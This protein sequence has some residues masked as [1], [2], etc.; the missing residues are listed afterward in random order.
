MDPISVTLAS[1]AICLGLMSFI[2]ICVEAHGMAARFGS[3][4]QH[5][6]EREDERRRRRR[7]N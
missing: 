7:R 4:S 2:L 1:M 5:D 3:L 6:D